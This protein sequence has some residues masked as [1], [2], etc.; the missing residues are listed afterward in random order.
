MKGDVI[1]SDFYNNI[2]LLSKSLGGLWLRNK[3]INQNIANADTPNYKRISVSF[4]D[5][6]RSA[7]N[8]NRTTLNITHKN[9]ISTT[10]SISE[11]QPEINVDRSYSYRFDGNNV[12][13]DVESANLAKNSIMYSAVANQI[14]SEFE[15]I[16]NV[17]NEG[18][19]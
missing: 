17:I 3:A 10:K 16:K 8:K 9:H 2:E 7:I 4:E 18:S 5:S 6:L 14:A 12:D 1:M 19:R 11:I 15:K 13:I